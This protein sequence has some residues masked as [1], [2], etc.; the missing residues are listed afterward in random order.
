MKRFIVAVVCA[1][2][3]A[4]VGLGLQGCG[5]ARAEGNAGGASS[6]YCRQ[7]QPCSA[8]SFRSTGTSTASLPSCDATHAGTIEWDT[9]T[10]S[11]KLC[12]GTSWSALG[13]SASAPEETIDV[14]TW[15]GAGGAAAA[16]AVATFGG[17]KLSSTETATISAV[18]VLVSVAGTGASTYTLRVSD[19]S[20][21]NCDCAVSCTGG[22]LQRASCTGVAGT[23]C[24]YAASKSLF[25]SVQ[26]TGCTAQPT[27]K[28]IAYHGVLN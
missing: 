6:P 26:S 20:G 4:V 22:S 3:A 18:S 12:N 10:S 16:I 13:T 25:Y 28:S 8:R 1:A 21:D 24:S 15:G 5:V 9:T 2:V 23:G 17:H 14:F 27:V 7:G 11:L 19:G